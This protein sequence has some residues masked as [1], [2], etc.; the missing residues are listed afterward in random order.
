MTFFVQLLFHKH[1]QQQLCDYAAIWGEVAGKQQHA[2]AVPLVLI[3]HLAEIF[4]RFEHQCHA[5][6]VL[7]SFW[8]NPSSF[9]LFFCIGQTLRCWV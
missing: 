7:I 9:K 8:P 4:A 6:T 2:A 3:L 1:G 5:V